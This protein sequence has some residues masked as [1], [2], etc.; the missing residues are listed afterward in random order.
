MNVWKIAPGRNASLWDVALE[1]ESIF[2]G[3]PQMGDLTQYES[4]DE[5]VERYQEAFNTD[6]NPVHDSF[7]LWAFCQEMKPGDVVI[8]NNGTRTLV[9]IGKVMGDY[10]YRD[11]EN[12]YKNFRKVDWVVREEVSFVERMFPVKALAAVKED[13]LAII[14]E[15]VIAQLPDGR[16]KWERLFGATVTEEPARSFVDEFYQ[17]VRSR[18]FHFSKEIL[19]RFVYSLKSKPFVI[20]SGISGTG[21]TKIAQLFAEFMSSQEAAIVSEDHDLTFEYRL[22]PYNFK[23]RRIIVPQSL[24]E[25]YR[26]CSLCS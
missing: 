1:K 26:S 9:G 8:A 15:A 11:E 16:E 6:R 5:L 19:A 24:V 25:H 14:K 18:N 2:I 13:R 12:H 7:T 17:F 22:H 23:Y 4:R 20:L 3:W 21:K 10:E